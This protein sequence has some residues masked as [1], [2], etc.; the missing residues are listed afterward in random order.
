MLEVAKL[1]PAE[2]VALS[3]QVEDNLGDVLPIVIIFLEVYL[4]AFD[5]KALGLDWV[6]NLKRASN[7]V[8]QD[9]ASLP[10]VCLDRVDEDV[11]Q[12]VFVFLI[13]VREERHHTLDRVAPV[14]IP[15]LVH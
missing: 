7:R 2:M 3:L 11:V 15:L 14:S 8:I 1:I 12:D 4:A 10:S 9:P 6:D 13:H 5:S